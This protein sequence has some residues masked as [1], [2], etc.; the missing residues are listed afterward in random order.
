MSRVLESTAFIRGPD[1]EAFE[2]ELAAYTGSTH[3]VGCANG[4]D[5][6]QISLMAL[7][8]E[9]GDE[10][11]T[12]DFTYFATAE[13]IAL[14]RLTPVLVDVGPRTFTVEPAAVE[15]AVTSRTKAILPVHLFGQCADMAPLLATAEKHGLAVVEDA[16]Q[17][18]GAVYTF[19]DGSRKQAGTMGTLGATSFFPSKNLGC[20]GDGGAI[21]TSDA[22]LARRVRMISNHGQSSKYIHDIVG[23]NSRLDTLQAAVLRVKL[24][25]LDGYVAARQAL[26]AKYDDAFAGL[27]TLDVPRRLASSSHV[28]HQYTVRLPARSR[29]RIAT[30]LKGRGVPTAVY[31]PVPIHAQKAFEA[32]GSSVAAC[33]ISAELSARVLSLP[34]HT[35]MDDEQL[36]HVTR[37]VRE[38][39]L[40]ETGPRE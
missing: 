33:P 25:Y 6:L 24:R 8:L 23:V 12:P 34:M 16:A 29:D 22:Q 32:Y 18:I 19:P 36:A 2:A 37:A 15:R 21:F 1:V 20:F 17:A 3:V 31:Y 40:A 14:L 26:A 30:G 35:E 5:A 10:V 38:T 13:V 28:F 39:V 7:G 11:I 4:T 9:P 27:A